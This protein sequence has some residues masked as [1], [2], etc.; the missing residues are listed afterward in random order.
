MAN[1]T[2]I[3]SPSGAKFQVNSQYSDRFQG[4]VNDLEGAG[5]SIN[6]GSSYGYSYRNIAG[7][8]TLSNHAFGDAIDINPSANPRLG[9]PFKSDL[10]T[11]VGD[12]AAKNGLKWGGVWSNP[13][14]MH[15]EVD[16]KWDGSQA[17]T[18]RLN[19]YNYR[20]G[21]SN[22]KNGDYGKK[23]NQ[24]GDDSKATDHDKRSKETGPPGKT[25]HNDITGKT[26]N[27]QETKNQ[28]IV[29]RMPTH[30]PWKG[31]PKSTEGPRQAVRAD[32]GAN[33]GGTNG[34]SGGGGGGSGT[35]TNTGSTPGNGSNGG[36]GTGG[37]SG[38]QSGNN[39]GN[40]PVTA[41]SQ[42]GLRLAAFTA[43]LES[44]GSQNQADVLQSM[45]NRAGQ[46]YGNNGDLFNQITA[47]GQ[48]API[49]SAI[50]GNSGG[51]AASDRV[52]GGVK[53]SKQELNQLASRD[54]WASA[55]RA[56]FGKGDA[57]AAQSLVSD[58]NSDG[59]L[60]QKAADFVGGR[61]DFRG[62]SGK[63][64]GEISRGGRGAN[65]FRAANAGRGASKLKR[66]KTADNG[67]N[68]QQ[69]SQAPSPATNGSSGGSSAKPAAD[70]KS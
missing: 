38:S 24:K 14:P 50:S 42:A 36:G 53:V 20:P 46:N 21:F 69:A 6:K 8:N 39:T 27:Y 1:L 60:S 15:F 63:T 58:F 48:Y 44:T 30:E 67:Q 25:G 47:K 65:S 23:G 2:T 16:K 32:G 12:I 34:G 17:S 59:P 40:G 5:Y 51:D 13:D 45:V 49:S 33:N 22:D 57:N 64:S 11:D 68:A 26:N 9:G 52:F 55:L 37:A 43:T 18:D 28:S 7:T 54:D 4:F 66:P 56:R 70:A 10:P 3:F 29:S 35:S 61:T 41:S 62:Y 31:H 19:K